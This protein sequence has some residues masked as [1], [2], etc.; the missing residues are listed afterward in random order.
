ML[1]IHESV[2]LELR[3]EIF[4]IFVSVETNGLGF[5]TVYLTFKIYKKYK[6]KQNN[7]VFS[8]NLG[9]FSLIFGHNGFS[10]VCVII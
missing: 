1:S 2:R 3:D 10:K 7:F 9:R 8:D 6:A 5:F 4:I